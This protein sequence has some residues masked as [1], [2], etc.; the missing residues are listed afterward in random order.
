MLTNI[1][2]CCYFSLPSDLDCGICLC[3]PHIKL[4]QWMCIMVH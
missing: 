4:L 2:C 1:F 3:W